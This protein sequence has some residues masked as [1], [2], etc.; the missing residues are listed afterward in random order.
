MYRSRELLSDP[1]LSLVHSIHEWEVLSSY[2]YGELHG[3]LSSYFYICLW[4]HNSQNGLKYFFGKQQFLVSSKALGAF[5]S[6]NS[7]FN[8]F[9]ILLRTN[10]SFFDPLSKIHTGFLFQFLSHWPHWRLK[11]VSP[12][13]SSS[14]LV[15]SWSWCCQKMKRILP[16]MGMCH[17]CASI[18]F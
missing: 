18:Y 6:M 16:N 1:C 7:R 5:E 15:V 13:Y 14:F 12:A 17:M 2:F 10:L 8:Y 4:E 9:L 3:K 11:I